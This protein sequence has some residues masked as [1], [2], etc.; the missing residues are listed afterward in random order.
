MNLASDRVINRQEERYDPERK[1]YK[2]PIK[3]AAAV[4]RKNKVNHLLSDRLI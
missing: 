2:K 4:G 3:K 1:G